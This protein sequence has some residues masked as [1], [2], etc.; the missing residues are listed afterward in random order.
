MNDFWR[1]HP[2]REGERSYGFNLH[3]IFFEKQYIQFNEQLLSHNT[4]YVRNALVLA[5]V[6]EEP[7]PKYLLKIITDALGMAGIESIPAPKV[8][9]EKYKNVGK[10][11]DNN[12]R[13][14][15]FKLKMCQKMNEVL[16]WI[17]MGFSRNWR[18]ILAINKTSS[19]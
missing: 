2:F 12:C 9:N 11:K 14:N 6:E 3:E 18:A 16:V 19:I 7:E 17:G 5:T 1:T 15:L 13:K 8:I 4:G 10:Y